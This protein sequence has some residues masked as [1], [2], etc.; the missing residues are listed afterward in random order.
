MV[1]QAVCLINIV[2]III[3]RVIFIIIIVG[4]GGFVPMRLNLTREGNRAGLMG[5][6]T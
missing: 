1:A 2:I 3:G 5:C 6:R 4:I